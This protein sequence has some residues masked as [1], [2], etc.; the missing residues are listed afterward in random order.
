MRAGRSRE[1]TARERRTALASGILTGLSSLVLSGSAAVAA[2]ILAQ[3]FGRDAGTDGLLAAYGVYVTLTLA[4]QAL[5][6]TAVPELTRTDG[7]AVG[8]FA[9]AVLVVGVPATLAAWLFADPLAELLTGTLPQK[10]AELAASALPW[11]VGAAFVQV[12]AALAAATLAAQNR[13]GAAALG[14]SAGG[15]AGLVVFVALADE[16]GL[17]ALAWGLAA[18]AAIALGVP[19]AALGGTLGRLRFGGVGRRLVL[20]A[21]AAAV[22]LALQGLYLI[23]LRAASGLGVGAVT[24]FSYAYF[25][26]AV[27]VAATATSL[28]IISTAELTRRGV[29]AEAAVEHVVHGSWLCLPPIAAAAG[30]FAL[31]GDRIAAWVLGDAFSGEVGD[32]LARLVVVLAPWTIA[33]VGF[34]LAL[35]LLYVLERSRVLVPVA[36]GALVADVPLSLGLRELWGLEGLAL[37]LGLTTLGVL[38]A[39][40]LALSRRALLAAVAS[41]V[42]VAVSVGALALLS[43]GALALVADDALAASVGLAVYAV[44]LALVRPSGLRQAWGYMRELH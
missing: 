33:A 38:A 35:P 41:L 20:L 1:T 13:F 43:F 29:E 21:E 31:V 8:S 44:L 18:N 17:V 30:V 40:L 3:K 4:A 19:L 14:F 24:S 26:A 15:I 42:R 12:L 10:A 9:A 39:L 36:L 23:A 27:L 25:F 28:S 6:L 2:A 11:L 34:S 22:P 7:A 5:R 32:E 16:H 37:A